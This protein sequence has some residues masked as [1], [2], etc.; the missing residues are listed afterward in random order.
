MRLKQN[1]LNYFTTL[2]YSKP[3]WP[4]WLGHR[5]GKLSFDEKSVNWA[6]FTE[7]LKA[8]CSERVTRGRVRYARKFYHCLLKGDFS[9]L[10]S[11][12]DSKR[13]H[14]MKALSA[15]SKFLGVYED[16]KT[17]LK[18]YGLKWSVNSD[19][20]IISRLTKTVDSNEVFEWIKTVKREKPSLTDFMDFMAITGL[21]FIEALE[22]Y[23]LIIR[24][25]EEG[26][27]SQYYNEDKAV[28]EHFKFK[29]IFIRRTKKAF[30]SFVPKSLIEAI[31]RSKPLTHSYAISVRKRGFKLRFGDIREA[32]ATFLTKYLRESEID[33][34][35]GRVSA[36]VFMRNYFNPALIG[37]LKKRIF[38]AIED[39]KALI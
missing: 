4:S 9:E 21:R 19:D 15:L 14:V 24:L 39:L 30:I 18:N 37:D 22:S 13:I 34:L 10:N 25:A 26:K 23:N 36:S 12:S 16:Y 6:S 2:Q 35:H 20:I 28:L 38:Q 17:L 32:H 8:R 7:F 1:P 5:L 33:F 11:F 29:E 31:S 27:L 3:R